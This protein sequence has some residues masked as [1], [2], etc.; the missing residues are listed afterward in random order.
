MTVLVWIALAAL[1]LVGMATFL[2]WIEHA[3]QAVKSLKW[4]STRRHALWSGVYLA[5]TFLCAV[6]IWKLWP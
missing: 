3:R 1:L 6:G 5:L 4:P 2:M